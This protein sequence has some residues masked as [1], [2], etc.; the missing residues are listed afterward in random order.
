[1]HDFPLAELSC[2]LT[3]MFYSLHLL[4]GD[5]HLVNCTNMH[6]RLYEMLQCLDMTLD[7]V[8]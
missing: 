3:C 5:F 7:Y 4:S 2:L 1:M 8:V 6:I